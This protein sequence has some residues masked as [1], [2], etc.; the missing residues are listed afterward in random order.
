YTVSAYDADGN[1]GAVS[2]AIAGKGG[3]PST[4]IE[5]LTVAKRGTKDLTITWT[6]R[7]PTRCYLQWGTAPQLTAG[8]APEA[9][10]S[11]THSVTLSNLSRF[12]NYHFRVVATDTAGERHYSATK[13][14]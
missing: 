14:A 13:K 12:K 10:A 8:T 9:Q 6:T 2:Q 4:E 11:T 3:L 1:E 7:T 5:G